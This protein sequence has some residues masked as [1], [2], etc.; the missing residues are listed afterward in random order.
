[1]TQKTQNPSRLIFNSNLNT[2]KSKMHFRFRNFKHITIIK[3]YVAKISKQGTKKSL[4]V[5]DRWRSVGLREF[6][7]STN[8]SL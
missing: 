6:Y 1:M 5:W 4:Y 2:L 3:T 7:E 8:E